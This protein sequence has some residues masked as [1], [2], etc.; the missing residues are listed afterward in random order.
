MRVLIVPNTGNPAATSAA[1]SLA[2]W[3]GEREA[4]A[5]LSDPDAQECGLAHLAV[6]SFGS[7]DLV[8]ALG[9]D[10]T[11]LKA[12]HLLAG[13]S[14]PILG[15]NLGRLGFLSGAQGTESLLPAVE[16]A[17]A[18]EG[19][20]ERRCTLRIGAT[21]GGL[22]AGT[23]HALNEVF[24]GRGPGGRAV[25]ISIA[26]DGDDVFRSVCDGVIVSTPT[27]S[28]AYAL[29]AGGPIVAPGVRGMLMVPTGAHTLASRPIVVGEDAAVVLTFPDSA[30]ADACV[31]VDGEA[32]PCRG[33]LDS[34]RVVV[35]A[36][37]VSLVRLD[38]R[39]FYSVL[40]DTFFGA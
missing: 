9:G 26:I 23:H 19:T 15:V 25:D 18:G 3:L 8:V 39:T 20:I 31:V 4:E 32:V 21:A 2:A 16:A 34:V 37:D 22:D 14:V 12:V 35:G 40:R 28:T 1:R 5:V 27:G 30:R 33:A 36:H 6:T 17:V 7:L 24:V 10:G 38:G 29:S 11:I 13:E